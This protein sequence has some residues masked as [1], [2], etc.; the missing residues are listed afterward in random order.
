[1]Q[2]LRNLAL[3]LR[4]VK[5]NDSEN[6]VH[7][8]GKYFSVSHETALLV[9]VLQRSDVI[10]FQAIASCLSKEI[11]FT[12]SALEVSAE[13]EKLP[14]AFFQSYRGERTMKRSFPILRGKALRFV[15]RASSIL[16][17]NEFVAALLV[18]ASIFI[19][20]RGG[21]SF[22]FE[23]YSWVIGLNVF[24]SIIFHE[25]GH[26]SACARAGAYPKEIAIGIRHFFPTFYTDVSCAWAL[27]RTDRMMI[28]IAGSVYQTIFAGL[29]AL[30]AGSNPAQMISAKLITLLA[31]FS[32]LPYFRFDGYWFVCDFL[33]TNNVWKCIARELVLIKRAASR[34][35]V[36]FKQ[37]IT[38]AGMLSYVAGLPMLVWFMCQSVLVS[39]IPG[40]RVVFNWMKSCFYTRLSYQYISPSLI[41]MLQFFIIASLFA[42][43]IIYI[44][45]FASM[46]WRNRRF[47]GVLINDAIFM[48][49]T[50][51]YYSLVGFSYLL[52]K[53]LQ[54]RSRYI[55][56]AEFGLGSTELLRP[57]QRKIALS[58]FFGKL[59]MMG[60]YLI[61]DRVSTRT[62]RWLVRCTHVVRSG[63]TF[64][65]IKAD[66]SPLL[67]VV[68]HYGSFISTAIKVMEEL[69]HER[70]VNFIYA[71]PKVDI[72]NQRYEGFFRRYFKD[73][74][75]CYN[76]RAGIIFAAK[77][78]KRGEILFIM[79]DVFNGQNQVDVEFFDRKIG[80]MPGVE[81]FSNKFD[82][83]IITMLT[84]FRGLFGVDIHFEYLN[85]E[86]TQSLQNSPG[87]IMSQVF[88][89]LEYWIQQKPEDWHNWGVYGR[90]SR[91]K[92]LA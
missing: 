80:V 14:E 75:I 47:V 56:E 73:I 24:A 84:P 87:S 25:I 41:E 16:L 71:D 36:S 74:S 44:I 9:D 33:D 53:S 38:G 13:Y 50:V 34:K 82:A 91:S 37:I 81:Y 40:A 68:P 78:L 64:S 35:E 31:V 55:K 49:F 4:V 58:S 15:S 17:A 23:S 76:N 67:I 28:D 22:A 62:G 12:V 85:A 8:N 29:I 77:A 92:N 70:K 89:R 79:P 3:D 54:H 7:A 10:T 2:P 26:A 48:S 6:I 18:I 19:V 63:L 30:C 69:G 20:W 65:D 52:R 90:L 86:C 72:D 66:D 88:A 1:M 32:M 27:K 5:K 43:I 59:K 21:I 51:V 42:S 61:L 11:G 60:W 83:K 57:R 45:S 46:L 39:S